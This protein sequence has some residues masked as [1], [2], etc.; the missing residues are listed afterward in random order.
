MTLFSLVF[1]Q[2]RQRSLSTCLTL[3]S[4]LLGVALTIAIMILQRE[5]SD[6]FTQKDYGYELIVGP[7]KGSKL[8]LVLN[9]VYHLDLSPGNVPYDLYEDLSRKSPPPPGRHDF[10]AW[11]RT[12]IPFMVGDSYNGNRIVGTSPQMFGY[13]DDGKPVQGDKFQYR[14]DRSFELAAGRIFG[15]RKFEAVLGSDVAVK[16]KFNLY[17]PKLSEE[18]NEQRHAVLQATHGVLLHGGIPDIHKPKWHVVGILKTTHTS[19]DRVLFIPFISLYAIEEHNEGMIEQDLINKNYDPNTHSV[20]QN[21]AWLGE[22]GFDPGRLS[23]KMRRRFGLEGPTTKP[24]TQ[25]DVAPAAGEL[26]KSSTPPAAPAKAAA[27]SGDDDEP[28]YELDKNGDI[29]PFLPQ[30]AWEL[31]AILIKARSAKD[32]AGNDLP[33]IAAQQLDYY[34]RVNNEASAAN[35]AQVMR[36][37][38]DTFLSG[39]SWVLLIIAFLVTIVAGVGILVSIYNSVTARRREIAILRA[40]G[41]TRARVLTLICTEAG[42]I[43]LIGGILGFVAGHACGIVE[44]AILN[45][46]EGQGIAW[47]TFSQWEFIFLAAVVVLAVLA[48]LVPALKAYMTPVATNL[49]SE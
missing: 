20:E 7:P 29:Q 25:E 36:D 16:E 35:P 10:R 31:S 5:A 1:K 24:T 3:V 32:A 43:G 34:F 49:I 17:D 39:W 12:A 23:P 15:P 33:G 38:F 8:Q 42:L 9:T 6:L 2:M 11:V 46:H 44:S 22:E 40:L 21:M 19:N 4:V 28:A 30:S 48:G 37:F 14:K 45:Y 13:D 41:A 47:W 26:L 18:Q 27:P